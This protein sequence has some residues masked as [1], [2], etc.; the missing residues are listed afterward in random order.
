MVRLGPQEWCLGSRTFEPTSS[1]RHDRKIPHVHPPSIALAIVLRCGHQL[2]RGEPPPDAGE[3]HHHVA[4]EC[5]PRRE[6]EGPEPSPPGRT[7]PQSPAHVTSKPVAAQS[8]HDEESVFR[9]SPKAGAGSSNLPEGTNWRQPQR[10]GPR[11]G[12]GFAYDHPQGS[13]V[14]ADGFRL[15]GRGGRSG[16]ELD[17]SSRRRI[18]Q[19]FTH[20]DVSTPGTPCVARR[21]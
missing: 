5:P 10:L 9:R 8:N 17:A 20:R 21:G 1:I 18:A 13:L 2:R 6:P 4:E 7:Q 11:P 19:D 15:A 3:R 14:G 12:P 16:R